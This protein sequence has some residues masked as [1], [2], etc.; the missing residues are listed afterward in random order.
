MA[1]ASIAHDAQTADVVVLPYI[2]EH[3]LDQDAANARSLP[4]A[5]VEIA[6]RHKA[7]E[8]T[9]IRTKGVVVVPDLRRL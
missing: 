5:Q 1:G 2:F 7:D 3:S 6:S 8:M 4:L 9:L